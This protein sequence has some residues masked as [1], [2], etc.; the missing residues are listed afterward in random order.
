ML[1]GAARRREKSK[2]GREILDRACFQ[3]FYRRGAGVFPFLV[4]TE[5][6]L[7]PAL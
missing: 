2:P 3:S 6:R 4:E 5:R 7:T 1:G